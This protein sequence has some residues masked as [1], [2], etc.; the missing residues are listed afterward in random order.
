LLVTWAMDSVTDYGQGIY[1]IDSCFGRPR[2]NAVHLIV[3][4]GHA[5]LIDTANNGAVPR[6]L[7]A[8]EA[9]GIS[10]PQVDYVILTHVHLDHAGGAGQLLAALPEAS[11]VVHPRGVR[12]M[13]D[14]SRLINSTV[15][16]YGQ[17][18]ARKMYG[19][20]LPVATD[21]IIEAG[22][23]HT[24]LLAGR[25]LSFLDTPGHARHHLSIVDGRSGHIF[26]GDTF[27]LSYRELDNNGRC[28]AFPATTPVQFDPQALHRSV[29]LLAGYRPEA[30]YVTHFSQVTDIPRLATDLHRLIDAH[31]EMALRQRGADDRHQRLKT[32]LAEIVGGEAASQGWRLRGEPLLALMAMDI[33]LNAQGLGAWLDTLDTEPSPRPPFH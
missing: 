18:A 23:G 2:L 7:A 14:P 25:E 9:L 4:N 26:A 21:R 3:E 1:A 15:A 16:V 28:F 20:V 27:G 11:L 12:H 5:A 24:L 22:H 8:L 10:P 19:E 17:S 29:D 33:E 13:T 32:G 31:V 6:V 30:I